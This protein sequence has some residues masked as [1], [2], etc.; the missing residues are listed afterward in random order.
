M[1]QKQR[2][3]GVDLLRILS[4]LMIVTMHV[5]WQGGLLRT[6]DPSGAHYALGWAVEIACYCAVNCY[7]MISGY[8][9]CTGRLRAGRVLLMWL[10]AAFYAVGLRLVCGALFPQTI[11]IWEWKQGLRPIGYHFYWYY[12]AYFGLTLC[13]PALNAALRA[14]KKREC[15]AVL[16]LML[17]ACS[18]LTT[19]SKADGMVVAKGYSVL[20]LAVLYLLGGYV[21][22]YER[23]D[24]LIGLLRRFGFAV[25][26]LSA[27]L[28]WLMMVGRWWLTGGTRHLAT[29]QTITFTYPLVVVCAAALFASMTGVKPGRRMQRCIA[30]L[31][32][33]AFGVYLIHA[34][35]DVW[36]TMII[37][38]FLFLG[39]VS[40]AALV[41]ALAASVIGVYAVCTAIER[42]RMRM[43][44]L[45]RIEKACALL[46]EYA[47]RWLYEEN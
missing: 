15:Q 14:M 12:S 6:A 46:T 27:A 17:F 9:G 36:M 43:F 39:D 24:R 47:D 37:D 10:Q 19:Y 45:L 2:N 18:V 34:N 1:A 41:P 7:G 4:M 35:P 11:N 31:S 23:E 32:P 26:L 30:Y 42:L 22:L 33:A 3:Y 5:L 16:A 40:A 8:V 13:T 38:R 20:W 28:M 44:A 29:D 25:Y 21:R